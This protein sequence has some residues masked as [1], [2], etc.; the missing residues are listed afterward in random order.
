MVVITVKVAK[1]FMVVAV[2]IS[3]YIYRIPPE[4]WPTCYVCMCSNLSGIRNMEAK[5]E[6]VVRHLHF[7]ST[8]VQ[9]SL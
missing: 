3:V 5:H 6:I 2:G 9:F 7:S 1:L 8:S 4:W